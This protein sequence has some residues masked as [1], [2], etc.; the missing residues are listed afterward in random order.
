MQGDAR[1]GTD[2]RQRDVSFD[3]NAAQRGEK[4]G[5]VHVV[6]ESI[7][8]MEE[9]D[10][11]FDAVLTDLRMPVAS[12]KTVLS[13]MKSLH[14][15]VLQDFQQNPHLIYGLRIPSFPKRDQQNWANSFPGF[16]S[17]LRL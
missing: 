8:Q 10:A 17:K 2:E 15:G 3:E 6:A 7:A 14:P 12:G 16:P 9:T 1:G 11:E 5:P 13:A 4:V